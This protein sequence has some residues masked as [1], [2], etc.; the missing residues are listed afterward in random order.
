MSLVTNNITSPNIVSIE[1]RVNSQS[2][3][4]KKLNDFYSDK[5]KRNFDQVTKQN[6]V[7]SFDQTTQL[8]RFQIDNT[9]ENNMFMYQVW[10]KDNIELNSNRKYMYIS[11]RNWIAQINHEINFKPT[12]LIELNGLQYPSI[13][14]SA[15][16]EG[17]SCVFY[18]D[19]RRITYPKGTIITPIPFSGSYNNVRFDIDSFDNSSICSDACQPTSGTDGLNGLILPQIPITLYDNDGIKINNNKSRENIYSYLNKNCGNISDNIPILTFVFTTYCDITIT[20]PSLLQYFVLLGINV[21]SLTINN[22]FLSVRMFIDK[23]NFFLNIQ[24]LKINFSNGQNG[25]LQTYAT[26]SD[27]N[28]QT[29]LNQLIS[30]NSETIVFKQPTC[31]TIDLNTCGV[32]GYTYL[33]Q[34]INNLLINMVPPVYITNDHPNNIPLGA[35]DIIRAI[36][37]SN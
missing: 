32:N 25:T 11:L 30:N 37:G 19:S 8:Y 12:T 35:Q 2:N 31:N 7:I 10:K 9:Q 28:L 20:K 36:S 23:T 3:E 5:N 21:S 15:A 6:V 13:L 18:F 1:N 16:V 22:I 24:D 33:L 27:S 17:D 29:I 26:V 14:V 4:L 34:L